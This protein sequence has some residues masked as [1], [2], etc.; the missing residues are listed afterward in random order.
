V[1]L[2]VKDPPPPEKDSDTD[3]EWDAEKVK[4][5]AAKKKTKK[6]AEEAAAKAAKEAADAKASR[7]QKRQE[8]LERGDNLEEL[9]LAESEEEKIIEDVSIDRLVLQEEEDGKTLPPVDRFILL[10]FPQTETHC[11][12]LK[13]FNI[14]FDRILL[15]S[16][17]ENEEDPGKEVTKRMTEIEEIA[18]DWAAE[19]ELSNAI[20]AVIKEYLG[21]DNQEKIMELKDLTGD[22]D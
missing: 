7:H 8:A 21:E 17:E 6:K 13:E 9:G 2:R 18:Y 22:I 12:K 1:P 11:N 20:Q 5:H 15:L 16:E 3:E 14:D 19:L 4:A 10:G